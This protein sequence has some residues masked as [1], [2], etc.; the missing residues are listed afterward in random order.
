MSAIDFKI[1]ELCA[2]TQLTHTK[3]AIW[4]LNGFWNDGAQ[5]YAEDVWNFTQLMIELDTGSV[6]RYKGKKGESQ[7]NPDE[8]SEIDEFK[9]HIFLEKLG[10]TLTVVALRKRLQDLDVDKS[11]KLA[12]TEYLMAK[13]DRTPRAVIDAPQGGNE[14]ELEAAAASLQEVQERM[15]E[16]MEAMEEQKIALAKLHEEEAAAKQAVTKSVAAESE[17]KENLDLQH[18]QEA[19]VDDALAA[20]KAAVAELKRQEDEF[21]AK[22]ASLDALGEDSTKGVVTRNKAKNEAAQ[23]R[24]VDPLPLRTAKITAE[25]AVRRVEKEKKKA[26][27]AT[28]KAAESATVAATALKESEAAAAA[29][30]TA[31]VAAEQAKQKVRASVC[32]C[33]RTC[34][35]ICVCVCGYCFTSRSNLPHSLHPHLL[36]FNT[37]I[38]SQLNTHSHM[39]TLTHTHC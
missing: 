25:A 18:K 3:Q 36:C 29:A 2:V 39:H 38:L 6:I 32:V 13:Y 26:A 11:K 8:G 14:K 37:L 30:E 4:W 5:E 22:L 17:A 21:N 15:A 9:A 7:D 23:M 31:R 20:M 16:L 19:V 1:E 33:T 34:A 10:E 24:D 35:C 27:V 28:Q 12:M